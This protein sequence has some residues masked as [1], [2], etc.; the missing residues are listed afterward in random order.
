MRTDFDPAAMSRN[1]FYKLLTA[2]VVPRPIAWV[3]TTSADGTHNLAP[4][5]F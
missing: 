3:S 4:A 1:E 5:K 2:T